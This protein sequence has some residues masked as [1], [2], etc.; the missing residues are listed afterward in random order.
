MAAYLASAEA[1][2]EAGDH[3]GAA[4]I[5]KQAKGKA[6]GLQD[7]TIVAKLADL[8]EWQGGLVGW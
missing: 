4:H 6:H 2:A 5:L 8:Q 3:A 1:A 7:D